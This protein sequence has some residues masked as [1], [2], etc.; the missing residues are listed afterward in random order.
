MKLYL[1]KNRFE[2]DDDEDEEIVGIFDSEAKMEKG[3]RDYMELLSIID[4]THFHF[5]YD[6]FILNKIYP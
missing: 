6:E 2:Y 1:L 5:S 3:K 4:E